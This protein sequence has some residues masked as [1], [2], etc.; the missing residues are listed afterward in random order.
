MVQMQE[1]GDEPSLQANTSKLGAIF[2]S[3]VICKRV[4]RL[5]RVLPPV[6]LSVFQALMEREGS[7]KGDQEIKKKFKID[8]VMDRLGR[9]IEVAEGRGKGWWSPGCFRDLA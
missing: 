8:E 6:A 4:G 9:A 3:K 1:G 7:E 5:K 2:G